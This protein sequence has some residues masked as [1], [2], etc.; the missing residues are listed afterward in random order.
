MLQPVASGKPTPQRGRIAAAQRPHSRGRLLRRIAIG[1]VSAILIVVVA[2]LGIVGWIGSERAIHRPQ[3]IYSWTLADYPNLR[4]EPVTIQSRTG[5]A[6]AGRFFPGTSRT[7]II[8][9]HGFGDNQDQLLPWADFLNRAGYS[10][11]TY[12]MRNRGGSGGDATTFGALEQEDLLS[13][14]DYVA[15]RPDVDAARLGAL[16]LSLG[17]ATT[18]LAAARDT[19]I[20]AVV[21]D[22]GFSD[23]PAV[24]DTAYEYFLHLPAFPFAPV[25]VK[26]GELRTGTDFG[27]V[28]P[29][30][31]VGQISPRPI[32][33]IHGL[34]DI[35]VP[36]AHSERV[37]AAAGE[38]KQVWYVPGAKH[39]GSREVAGAEYGQ[40]IVEFFRSTLG[41]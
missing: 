2:A 12:D 19:R 10:L 13:V 23:A 3:N 16:G 27:A 25:S 9:S 20:K 32:F 17:G 18:I 21:D 26:I 8:I 24:V 31:A 34:A 33:I 22:C 35:V 28:R 37:F 5:V 1:L 7:T 11:F 15:A 41:E 29:V 38:P 36:P 4:A 14:I 39:N 30:D 40:R 6:L